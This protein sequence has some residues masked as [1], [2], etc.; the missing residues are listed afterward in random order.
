L[1]GEEGVDWGVE[2]VAALEEVQLHEEEETG[3]N[4]AYL[5][6][7]VASSRG[8]ATCSCTVSLPV[9]LQSSL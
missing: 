8:A 6:D 1:A 4:A 7:E 9:S 5:G 3:H 2:L